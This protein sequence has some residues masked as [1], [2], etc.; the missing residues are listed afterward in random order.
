MDVFQRMSVRAAGGR[1][2]KL[3]SKFDEGTPELVELGREL[4]QMGIV[5]G[6][7]S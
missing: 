7:N 5:L 4:L 2:G 1:P 3:R 6:H